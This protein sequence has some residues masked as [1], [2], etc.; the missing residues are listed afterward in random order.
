MTGG[1]V[2]MTYRE[3]AAVRGISHAAAI[4]LVQRHRWQKR[5]GSNDGLAHVLVPHDAVRST[6]YVRRPRHTDLAPPSSRP[7]TPPDTAALDTALAAIEMAHA[8]EVAALRERA[9]TAE[10]ARRAERERAEIAE[11]RADRA[12]QRADQAEADRGATIALADQTVALLK[13]AVARAD[14]A[15]QG[16]DGER[17]R[18]D[19]LRDRIEGLHAQVATAEADAETARTAAGEATQAAETLRRAEADLRARGLWRRLRSAWRGE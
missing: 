13:D 3:I 16:R 18:A 5:D 11:Q 15:E 9:D 10:A 14:R 1:A 2:W 19:A 17:A 7:T 6:P 12:E 8:G 4:R